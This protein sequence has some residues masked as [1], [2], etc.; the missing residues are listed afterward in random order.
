VV[1]QTTGFRTRKNDGTSQ[2]GGSY[3]SS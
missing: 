3:L 1:V 2:N